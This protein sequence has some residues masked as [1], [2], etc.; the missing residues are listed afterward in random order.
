M[1]YLFNFIDV[2]AGIVPGSYRL[3]SPLCS[4]LV[5]SISEFPWRYMDIDL[6]VTRMALSVGEI[7][8]YISVSEI[9]YN[10]KNGEI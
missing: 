10:S 7:L 5:V 3:V 6:L 4:S 2:Y 8:N 1:Q 9:W